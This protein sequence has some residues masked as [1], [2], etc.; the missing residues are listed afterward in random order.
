MAGRCDAHGG[1]PIIASE[2]QAQAPEGQ[3]APL[4]ERCQYETPPQPL[5]ELRVRLLPRLCAEHTQHFLL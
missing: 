2:V 3:V 1:H 4:G 5:D